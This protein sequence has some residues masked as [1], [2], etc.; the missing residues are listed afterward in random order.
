MWDHT[1]KFIIQSEDITTIPVVGCRIK[2]FTPHNF[3]ERRDIIQNKELGFQNGY[4]FDSSEHNWI[5]M[6][7]YIC[8]SHS[9]MTFVIQE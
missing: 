2:S 7:E 5:L 4:R 3:N 9:F 8:L 1:G 6:Y